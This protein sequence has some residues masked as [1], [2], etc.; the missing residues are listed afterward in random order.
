LGA[1]SSGLKQAGD[2]TAK[3]PG[4]ANVSAL[5]KNASTA[6]NNGISLANSA[7]SAFNNVTGGLSKLTTGAS[8]SGG[9]SLSGL[10]DKASGALSKLGST[11]LS[12]LVS[13]GLPASV[14]AQL[15]SAISALSSGGP[16]PIKLPTVAT[17][18]SNRTGLSS[19]IASVLGSTKIPLPNF[20]K[21]PDTSAMQT[22]T[23]R[24]N[25][26]ID[27]QLSL[28][29][30]QEKQGIVLDKARDSFIAARDNLPAGDPEITAALD[31]YNA[32]MTKF[33]A[34]NDRIRAI[35]DQA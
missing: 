12:S 22:E 13:A 2:L 5:A 33:S 15:N 6:V 7:S 3:V 30:E 17:D 34:I 32:E 23:D 35:A 8:G 10:T 31:K 19:Q 4:L 27:E 9:L 18:T 20:S 29:K 14:G 1:I 11:S 24:L 16:F 28:L 26:L 25:K 21:S